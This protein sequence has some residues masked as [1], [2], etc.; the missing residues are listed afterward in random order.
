L[1]IKTKTKT[2]EKK[3]MFDVCNICQNIKVSLSI[4]FVKNGS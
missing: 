4:G 1:E 3:N 2:K